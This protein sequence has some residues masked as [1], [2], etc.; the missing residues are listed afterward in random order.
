MRGKIDEHDNPHQLDFAL[1]PG[2][3]GYGTVFAQVHRDQ[4]PEMVHSAPESS[5]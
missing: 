4:C 2:R 1:G 3:A 5:K